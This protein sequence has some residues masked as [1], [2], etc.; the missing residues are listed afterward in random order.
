MLVLD[1]LH[2]AD[3][4][5]VDLVGALLRRPPDAA[6]L[7]ALGARPRPAPE[8]LSAAFD[9][10]HRARTLVRIELAPLTPAEAEELLGARG[11]A[12][13]LY[14]EAGGNPF[15]LEQ[16]ARSPARGASA[17]GP[18]LGGLDV[19][20][21]V[22][23]A[24]AEE[25]ARLAGE[26][27]R[28]LAGAA[29]AGDPFTPELAAAAAGTGETAVL[30]AVD[31]LLG[32]DVVRITDAP[33]RF[34]FRHPLVRRAV[35][36][37]TPA[38]WRL[39]AHE[40]SAAALA[41]AGAP[42][43]DRAPHVERAGRAGDAA[44]V[45]VLREAGEAA[46]HRAPAS[47]A[48]WFGGALRLLGERAPAEQ[49]VE[50]LLARAR[51]LAA[52]GRFEDGRMALLESLGLVPPEAVA[53]R[54]RLTSA[55]AGIEHL[56]GRHEEAHARLVG[57]MEHLPDRAAPEAAALMIELAMDGFALMDYERMR[58]WGERA[59]RSARPLGDRPLIAAAAALL[60][61]ASAAACATADGEAHSTEAAR[62]V[63]DLADDELAARLDAAANL[64]GAELYLDRYADA[65][66][67]AARALAVAAATGQS[68]LIP[69]TYSILGQVK[70]LRGEPAEAAALLDDAVEGA[71]LSGNVQA[72]AGNLVNRSL[73]AVA[74]GDLELALDTAQ[75]DAELTRGL[76]QSLVCAAGYALATARLEGGDPAG[77][78]AALVGA[79]GG[80]ELVLIPGVWRVRGL[81][82]LTR[83]R[84]ALGDAD[85]AA[86]AAAGAQAAAATLGLCVAHS[87]ADRADAAVA[88]AAGDPGRA[89]ERA[90]ASAAAADAAGA[91]I[92]AALARTLAGRA[93][94]R[95]DRRGHAIAEL[96]RAADELHARGAR[97]FRDA[98]DRELRRLGRRPHRRTRPGSAGG[99]GIETLTEREQEVARLVVDRRTNA[100]IADALFLSPKT[101]ETHLRN[102]FHK[103]GVS[104][105]V[106]VARAVEQAA[107]PVSPAP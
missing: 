75:E 33:R 95:C 97:R 50:L 29:V 74:A 42:A 5:S 94:A 87:V 85:A 24:L 35:Y 19:P 25:L 45:A 81:E 58:M 90:L 31:T 46:A 107:R 2:W 106:A 43:A 17:S 30:D 105:R 68:E 98:A 82:L 65:E 27:R 92:E 11:D 89:A 10:A 53:L 104:S 4:A 21:A 59:L 18:E 32:L 9:R 70:L 66:A 34:R 38:G 16:L 69:I 8:R 44:A 28:V 72:L 93:L 48:R 60:A 13:A 52:G 77:A 83:G 103:L 6:V 80:E 36:E 56:L 62:L 67:H 54:V 3:P 47:A 26:P 76:D 61:F 7:L 101:V 23:A 99:T 15:Y 55:C 78:V 88:L 22:A 39:G 71:R 79:A 102:I 49:R 100:E 73:T 12:A 96:E 40:R 86:Q 1:D 37:S 41:A 91:P 51:T 84:L 57:A 20:A 14:E 64:A 63:G